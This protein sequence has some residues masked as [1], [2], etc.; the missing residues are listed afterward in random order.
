M[1][2]LQ[3]QKKVLTHFSSPVNIFFFFFN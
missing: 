3:I 2:T 1:G